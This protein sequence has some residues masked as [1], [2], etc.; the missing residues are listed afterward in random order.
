MGPTVPDVLGRLKA[1]PDMLFA[2][3][4]AKRVPKIDVVHGEKRQDD[5][6]WLRQKDH[7]DVLAHLRAENAYTDQVMK[8]TEAFQEALYRELLGRIK[9]DDQSVPYR[10]GDWLYYSRTEKGKQYQIH[11]RKQA[12]DG[13]EQVDGRPQRAGRG[14]RVHRPRRV[15]GQR[16]RPV[17]RVHDR[18]HGLPRVHALREGPRDRRGPAGPRREGQHGRLGG[19]TTTCC[20]TSPRTTP[21]ARTG[22][23][24]TGSARPR[25]TSSTRRPT[26]SSGS[27]SGARAAARS[28]SRVAQLHEHGDALPA[29]ARSRTACGRCMQPREKDHEYHVEHAPASSLLHPHER[30]RRCATSG[31]SRR[32]STDPAR[33]AGPRS[34]RIART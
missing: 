15:R 7:P 33:R 32:R 34:F 23:G 24:V 25:T 16:R 1:V 14:P 17:A 28:C 10:R 11:C 19:R 26:S 12:P 3:P 18:R 13:P 5:Y 22:S 9:E 29:R 21:S 8:P 27:A 2:P 4:A 20:S 31:S 6:F 30:R